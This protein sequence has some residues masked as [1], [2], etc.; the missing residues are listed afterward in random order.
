MSDNATNGT[1]L[2]GAING[3]I[4]ASHRAQRLDPEMVADVIKYGAAMVR[5]KSKQWR[6]KVRAMVYIVMDSYGNMTPE[7][8]SAFWEV[9]GNR[10]LGAAVVGKRNPMDKLDAL[11]A[12]CE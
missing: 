9:V 4:T 2:R 12:E 7:Q 8:K 6:N 1:M 5:G 3:A 10:Y 11:I